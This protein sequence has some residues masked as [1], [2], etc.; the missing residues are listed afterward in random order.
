MA[1]FPDFLN[2]RN[3]VITDRNGHY[4]SKCQSKLQHISVFIFGMCGA[5]FLEKLMGPQL[6]EQFTAFYV[7]GRFIIPHS[8]EPATGPYPDL[9]CA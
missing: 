8:Q 3:I 9:N 1:F 2:Q 7:I 5:V 6:L 4:I